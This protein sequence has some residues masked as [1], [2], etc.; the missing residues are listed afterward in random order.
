MGCAE[1]PRKETTG[2]LTGA[3]VGT[4][5]GQQV[6][7][8][9]GKSA[10]TVAGAILGAMVGASIGRSLDAQDEMRARQALEYNQT[11]QPASWVN[12]DSGAQV[13]V[14]PTRTYQSD[15]GQYCRE[16]TTD[17]VISGKRETAYGT[18]CRQ[19]DG[20]WKVVQ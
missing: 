2:A 6:G 16:Y 4:I 20:T 11:G 7:E 12:P 10:A 8:G 5:L 14:V 17:V 19:P 18:A 13:T 15:Y 1:A 9:S 3:V